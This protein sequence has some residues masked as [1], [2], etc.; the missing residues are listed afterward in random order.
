M[1]VTVV[2]DVN[3]ASIPGKENSRD[4]IYATM[5]DTMAGSVGLPVNIQVISYPH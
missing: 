3:D 4:V 1:P 2:E 5:R